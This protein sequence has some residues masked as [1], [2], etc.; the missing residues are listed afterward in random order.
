MTVALSSTT[1]LRTSIIRTDSAGDFIVMVRCVLF[2][3][4]VFTWGNVHSS[5]VTMTNL[6]LST[7]TQD[8]WQNYQNEV[9]GQMQ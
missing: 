1:V 2:G 5:V 3:H 9:N 4:F 6:V 7:H 8:H